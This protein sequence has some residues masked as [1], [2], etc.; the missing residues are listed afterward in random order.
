MV[1][2]HQEAVKVLIQ[3]H[4]RAERVVD[5]EYGAAAAIDVVVVEEVLN[6][7]AYEVQWVVLSLV[8]ISPYLLVSKKKRKE[9]K[10]K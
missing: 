9:K 8:Q 2:R 10:R 5:R 6:S 1:L 7:F 3:R 4:D